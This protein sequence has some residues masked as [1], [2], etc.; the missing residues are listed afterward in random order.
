M[1]EL[2]ITL[3]DGRSIRRTLANRLQVA[4]WD[5]ICV[6]YIYPDTPMQDFSRPLTG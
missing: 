5:V 3:T 1:A 4:D 2:V 6:T